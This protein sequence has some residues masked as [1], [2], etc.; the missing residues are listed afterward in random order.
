MVSPAYFG[1]GWLAGGVCSE[2]DPEPLPE[3]EA[4]PDAGGVPLPDDL[5]EPE[6]DF[7]A[8]PLP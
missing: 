5:P 1:C 2:P 7:A 3:P 8:P 6:S 4:L